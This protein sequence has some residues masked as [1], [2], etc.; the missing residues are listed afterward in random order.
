M[1]Y[2]GDFDFYGSDY[3][4]QSAH[5]VNQV[6]RLIPRMVIPEIL[7]YFGYFRD[8]LMPEAFICFL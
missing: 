3:D 5:G 2:H 4:D 6:A 7:V 8:V 1:R